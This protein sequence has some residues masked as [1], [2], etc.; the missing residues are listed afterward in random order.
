MEFDGTLKPSK[1]ELAGA[2][3]TLA[4]SIDEA[5]TYTRQIMK[6]VPEAMVRPQVRFSKG[7]VRAPRGAASETG[8][9]LKKRADVNAAHTNQP[10]NSK[11][12]TIMA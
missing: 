11:T 4:S 1:D 6:F 9:D 12:V 7:K 3:K 10:I 5:E 8:T 2:A